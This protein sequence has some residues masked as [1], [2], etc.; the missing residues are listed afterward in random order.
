M[1]QVH[2]LHEYVAK[3]LADKVKAR[4][5]VVLYDERNELPSARTIRYSNEVLPF[6]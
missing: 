5:V 1:Q 6:L 3:R 4:K 2:P